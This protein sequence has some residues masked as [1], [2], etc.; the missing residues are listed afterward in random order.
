MR[1]NLTDL[2]YAV[3][4]VFVPAFL[5]LVRYYLQ[6]THSVIGRTEA[7]REKQKEVCKDVAQRTNVVC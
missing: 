2:L 4:S 3:V 6:G 1:P 5:S 7:T